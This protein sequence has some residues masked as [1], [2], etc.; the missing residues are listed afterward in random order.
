MKP[1][2]KK[3]TTS[4]S[5]N[6]KSIRIVLCH[7]WTITLRQSKRVLPTF[8]ISFVFIIDDA[9]QK[10][11]DEPAQEVEKDKGGEGEQDNIKTGK[12][13]YYLLYMLYTLC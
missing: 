8:D 7:D 2:K 10:E 5:D 13:Y 1:K 4:N 12:S 9:T 11:T 3:K 6:G